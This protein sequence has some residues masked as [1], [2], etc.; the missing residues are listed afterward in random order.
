MSIFDN[1]KTDVWPHQFHVELHVTSIAGG[2]PADPKVA[3]AWLKT[4]LADKDDLIRAAVAETMVNRELDADTARE[5]VERNR[6]MVGFKRDPEHGLYIEGRQVKAM[7]KEAGSI[8][9]NE[10]R[11]PNRFGGSNADKNYRKGWK[12]WAPE[13]IFVLEDK[14]PLGVDEPSGVT[15]SFPKSRFGS[16]IQYTEY[17]TD[18]KLS[19]T[20]VTDHDFTEREWAH[21]WLTAEQNGI[22]AS[23][24]QGYGRFDVT[25]WERIS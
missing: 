1:Y 24:S 10:G 13:H 8:A 16:G 9:T 2:T 7:I 22:G 18:A 21:I 11:L 3:E 12:S 17:I 6:H 23:R 5:E 19:F 25:T 14:I 20:V 4:K 15:Q